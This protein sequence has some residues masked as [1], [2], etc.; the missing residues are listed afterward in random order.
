MISNHSIPTKDSEQTTCQFD[1][2][3]FG[4]EEGASNEVNS[5]PL[6]RGFN[7]CV[8]VRYPF[9]GFEINGEADEGPL[10]VPLGKSP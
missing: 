5:C 3:F 10:A 1:R 8:V 2:F 7:N 6:L 4:G 9:A